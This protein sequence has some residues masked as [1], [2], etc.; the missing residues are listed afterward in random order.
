MDPSEYM[1]S[2][3]WYCKSIGERR[4]DRDRYRNKESISR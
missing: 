1:Y 3:S 2:S 4:D